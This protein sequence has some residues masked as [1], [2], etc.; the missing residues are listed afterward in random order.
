MAQN[1]LLEPSFADA[2]A[3]IEQAKEL[4]AA[5]RTHWCC[6][7]RVIAK[8]LDRPPESIAA[9]WGAVALQVNQLHHANTGV[10]WKTLANH[11]AN[12]K[13][14]LFWFRGEQGLTRRGAPLMPA[15]QQL[16][17]RLEDPSRLAKLSGLIRYC[18]LKGIAPAA[19]DEAVVEAYMA[20]RKETTALAVDNKAR[21]A[22]AR[23][24]NASRSIQGWPQQQLLE[25]PLKAKEGPRWE[26][27][28]Q[29]LQADV[30]LHLKFLATHRR[31]HS[32]K[33]LR[34]CKPLTL[35]TR[36]MDLIG[37]AKKAVRLGIRINELTSLSVLLD[38]D[39]VGQILDKEWGANGD[40]PKTSTIDLVKKLVAVAR[41]ANCLTKEQLIEL[42][43][44]RATLEEYRRDGMTQKN[45]KLIRQVLN[46][47]IWA[48]VINCPDELMRQARRLKDQAPLKAAVTAQRAVAVAI[49]TAAPIRA[50]NLAAIQLGDNLVKPGG[51]DTPYLL[52]FPDYDVKNQVDLTFELDDFIT[53]VIDEYVH[54]YRP[55]VMRGS[56]ADW[57]FPGGDGGSK[58]S[59]L[60]GIQITDRIYKVTGLRMTLHQ[61]RHAAAAVYL[62]EHPGDYETVRR[63][64]GHRSIRTTVKFYCGL[65]TIQASRM[66]NEVIKR[67]RKIELDETC[68]S[69]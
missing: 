42:D 43:D 66:L 44:K 25:P 1:G 19:I 37:F 6:S 69:P 64:L 24:W 55:A 63:F 51:P 38:P 18:S 56:N 17:R 22:I 39:L 5:R 12:A 33:H 57:L 34:P 11:K 2:I 8:A 21:R 35:R 68:D 36:R 7:L 46:S 40:Q 15:W 47:D 50:A 3:A 53:A 27:F 58:D 62:K 28:P 54:D 29:Q 32:G 10:M 41:S 65:E 4:S 31:S 48:R 59:H 16:R 45:L 13:A 9:R 20:Y 52:V 61:Y 67:H 26:D 14:A 49:L 30:A 23:A 60:F